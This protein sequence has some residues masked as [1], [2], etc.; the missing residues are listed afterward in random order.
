MDEFRGEERSLEKIGKPETAF[1][2]V[3]PGLEVIH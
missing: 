3:I 2:F 1:L